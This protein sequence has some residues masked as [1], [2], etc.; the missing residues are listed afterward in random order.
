MSKPD[1]SKV[2]AQTLREW[3]SDIDA[4][5]EK[6]IEEEAHQAEALKAKFE[7]MAKAAGISIERILGKKPSLTT[8]GGKIAAATLSTLARLGRVKAFFR[9]GLWTSVSIKA[10]R[11]T[12]TPRL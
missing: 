7:E 4:C 11:A 5:L 2:S 10:P 8:K 3:R 9:N 1:F 6:A 12:P